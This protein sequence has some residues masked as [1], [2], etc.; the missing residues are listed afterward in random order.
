M[1]LKLMWSLIY[2]VSFLTLWVGL[3]FLFSRLSCLHFLLDDEVV[4]GATS[5][6]R[7][8]DIWTRGYF[9]LVEVDLMANGYEVDRDIY[10]MFW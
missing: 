2:C 8:H 6:R 9:P 3:L 5:C 4:S 10:R 1:L 7:T